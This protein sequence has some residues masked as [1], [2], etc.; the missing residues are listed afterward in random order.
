MPTELE[1]DEKIIRIIRK[2]PISLVPVFLAVGIVIAASFFASGWLIL[3]AATVEAFLPVATVTALLLA[4]DILMVVIG[5]L[6][7][8]IFMQNRIVLTNKH[9]VQV[10]QNSL[11][12]RSLSKFTLDELQD[13]VGSRR[14][15]FATLLNYGDLLIETAGARESF[16]FGPVADPLRIAEIINDSHEQFEK[17]H[18]YE[19]Q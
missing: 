16:R 7:I 5:I 12:D 11:L 14:G 2:H 10:M 9:L 13:V 3:N 15:L 1:S 8:I 4:V 19:R 6:A 18:I 17:A